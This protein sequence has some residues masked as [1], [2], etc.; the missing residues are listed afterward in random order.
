MGSLTVEHQE[1]TQF[2]GR[3]GKFMRTEEARPGVGGGVPQRPKEGEGRE[4]IERRWDC[5]KDQ[6]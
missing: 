5:V 3:R 2:G 4:E 1:D 6:V